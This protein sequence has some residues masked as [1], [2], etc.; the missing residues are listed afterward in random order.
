M[1]S[2]L[3]AFLT[4]TDKKDQLSYRILGKREGAGRGGE[5]LEWVESVHEQAWKTDADSVSK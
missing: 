3:M 5:G 2:E 4:M 1:Q